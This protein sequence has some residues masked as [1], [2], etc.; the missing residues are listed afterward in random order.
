MIENMCQIQ[1]T[2]INKKRFEKE[3][4]DTSKSGK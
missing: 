4:N 2:I 1:K 3:A